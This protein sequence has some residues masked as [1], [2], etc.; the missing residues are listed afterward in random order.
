MIPLYSMPV[1]SHL[2]NSIWLW[3]KNN[4]DK[5]SRFCEGP[6]IRRGLQHFPCDERLK[7]W[8]LFSLEKRRIWETEEQSSNT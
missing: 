8:G 6:L 5:W 1:G 4:V 2:G 3:H 7:E